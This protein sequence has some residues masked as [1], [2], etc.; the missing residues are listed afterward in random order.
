MTELLTIPPAA[1]A[2]ILASEPDA[3]MTCRQ[4]AIL[5]LIILRL[6][7]QPAVPPLAGNT[8]SESSGTI[9]AH[10]RARD[11]HACA[12]RSDLDVF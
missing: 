2:F 10:G 9:E 8:R 6:I 3:N 1:Q 12:A 7:A 4:V 11:P 5:A